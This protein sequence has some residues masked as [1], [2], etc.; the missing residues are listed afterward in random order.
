MLL[1]TT[2]RDSDTLTSDREKRGDCSHCFRGPIAVYD[3]YKFVT[4]EDLES[5]GEPVWYFFHYCI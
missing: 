3:D 5:L 2:F 1:S 4:K